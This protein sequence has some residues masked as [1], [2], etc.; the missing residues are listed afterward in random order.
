MTE[1]QRARL[2]ARLINEMKRGYDFGVGNDRIQLLAISQDQTRF[3][4]KVPGHTAWSGVG[5]RSYYPP[6]VYLAYPKQYVN[7]AQGWAHRE[8]MEV[9]RTNP[10][11]KKKLIELMCKHE[12]NI[13]YEGMLSEL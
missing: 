8:V 9:T 12:C 7:G 13:T 3:L 11:T 1:E 5:S 4:F 2:K 6:C 10:L